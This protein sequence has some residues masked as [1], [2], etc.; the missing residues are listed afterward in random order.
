MSKQEAE[1]KQ[2]ANSKAIKSVALSR[3]R[4]GGKWELAIG[5]WQFDICKMLLINM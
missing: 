2:A 4:W 1:T 5:G 3:R